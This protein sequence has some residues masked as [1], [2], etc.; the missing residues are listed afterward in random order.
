MMAFWP[1]TIVLHVPLK[2]RQ[3]QLAQVPMPGSSG[4]VVYEDVC[5]DK[6]LR[7]LAK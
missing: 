6:N 1:L 2:A 7:W 3:A 5:I 4:M